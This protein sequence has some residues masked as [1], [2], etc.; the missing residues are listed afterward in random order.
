[1]KDPEQALLDCPSQSQAQQVQV[2][3]EQSTVLWDT[4]PAL[5]H[6]P[7]FGARSQHRL[8]ASLPA[9]EPPQTPHFPTYQTPGSNCTFKKKSLIQAVPVNESHLCIPCHPHGSRSTC[10]QPICSSV[11]LWSVIKMRLSPRNPESSWGQETQSPV[12]PSQGFL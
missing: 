11:L 8:T 6:Q 10:E 9:D 3:L 5:L 4:D 12:L 7:T 1:M 2:L